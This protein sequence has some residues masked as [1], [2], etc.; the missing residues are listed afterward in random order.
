M[1]TIR[2]TVKLPESE[3][4]AFKELADRREISFTHALR[5]AIHSELFIQSLVDS[6]AKLLAQSRHG[7]LRELVFTQAAA[8]EPA[9]KQTP[10]EAPADDS[11]VAETL[12]RLGARGRVGSAEE[13]V[14]ARRRRRSDG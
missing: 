3:Y 12:K 7:D 5:Q 4:A 11:Y 6:G 8:P 2:T 10:V 14:A 9:P 13:E 1:S